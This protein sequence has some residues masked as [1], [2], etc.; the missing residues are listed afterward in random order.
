MKIYL[1]RHGES[2]SASSDDVRPLSE[3]GKADI[4]NLANF[5]APLKISVSRILHSKKLRAQQ[6]ANIL[7]ASIHTSQSAEIRPELDPDFSIM[8]IIEEI[9]AWQTDLMLVGHMPFMGKLVGKLIA[10]DEY[11]NIVSFSAGSLLCL[12]KTE[13]QQWVINWMLVPELFVLNAI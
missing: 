1:V 5:I 2:F 8:T 13:Y 12:E 11:K 9:N 10:D 4:Q 7:A 6:T 3:K